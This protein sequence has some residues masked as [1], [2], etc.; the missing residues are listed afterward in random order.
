MATRGKG[1]LRGRPVDY[2]DVQRELAARRRALVARMRASIA[3]ACACDL[4]DPSPAPSLPPPV[5]ELTE[6]KPERAM[7]AAPEMTDDWLRRIGWEQRPGLEATRRAISAG[8]E[9]GPGSLT[10]CLSWPSPP[11]AA[12]LAWAGRSLAG[13]GD[14]L[15]DG[16]VLFAGMGSTG[17][18]LLGSTFVNRKD[19]V[20]AWRP[21]QS[22]AMTARR[23]AMATSF[24]P[25]RLKPGAPDEFPC[26]DLVP[27]LHVNSREGAQPWA[28]QW[29]GFLKSARSFIER[30]RAGRYGL[31]RD[32]F[33][34]V[35]A[36]RPFAFVLPRVSIGRR[37]QDEIRAIPG[38]LDAVVLDLSPRWMGP[39]NVAE[40]LE[41]ALVDV[42][43][44]LR[45]TTLPPIVALVSDP[46]CALAAMRV[47]ADARLH[48]MVESIGFSCTFHVGF[49]DGTKTAVPREDPPQI[50][51]HGAATHEAEIAEALLELADRVSPDHPETAEAL[52]GAADTLSAMV[53]T[54]RPPLAD[55]ELAERR[56]TFVDAEER[57]RD[58][59][60]QE[61]DVPERS[62]IEKA[63]TLGR[64]AARRLMRD[65]PARMAL[66]EATAAALSGSRIGF[67]TDQIG[68]AIEARKQAPA[69]LI[70]VSRN[71][72]PAAFTEEQLD[73]LVLACRGVD[74]VRLLVELPRPGREAVFVFGP[75][76]AATAARIAEHVVSWPELTEAHARCMAL[77]AALPPSLGRLLALATKAPATR[78]TKPK[79]PLR[80]DAAL[81]SGAE[82]LVLFDDGSEEGFAAGSE[83]VVL[84][85][86]TPR[87]KPASQLNE[88]DLVVLPPQS[89]SDEVAREMG[90]DGEAALL[91]HDVGSYKAVLAAWLE[92]AG[93]KMTANEVVR[94]MRMID[95]HMS[96]PHPSTVRY[97]LSAAKAQ[98]DPTPRASIDPRWFAAFC[99]II[100]YTGDSNALGDH[101]DAHRAKLRRDG[102]LRRCL[103]ERFL[104]DRYDAVLHHDIPRETVD[105]LRR[106]VLSYVRA[107]AEV[108]RGRWGTDQ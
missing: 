85:V 88:G 26:D 41:L 11:A 13:E 102:Q 100:G 20:Q 99:R 71:E 6:A 3:T 29:K 103:V 14:V 44:G 45:R 69:G 2:V 59:L 104:F 28:P 67:V 64:D 82:V 15:G 32:R 84:S 60:R 27:L 33:G 65:T 80:S 91:D 37:R 47:A 68:D 52:A 43:T 86:K 66:A 10:V 54:T 25:N 7:E 98:K 107:V 96:V 18:Q 97:W 57:V 53:H 4:S 30:G 22:I 76:D 105:V 108:D 51:V 62:A 12:V 50:I 72:A 81:R 77:L 106:R 42:K 93:A 38:T 63:L 16:R 34:E 75:T 9:A 90:W 73:R 40:A 21:A 70:V 31:P 79:R 46:R 94:Q 36:T 17:A 55:K 58:A 5:G 49:L 92:G 19:A 8:I 78:G 24:L 56:V 87:V 74:A 61:G 48:E 89:V 23:D 83:V 1:W 95:P 35:S 39:W 101:F